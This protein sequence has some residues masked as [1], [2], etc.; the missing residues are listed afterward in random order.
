M[1]AGDRSYRGPARAICLVAAPPPYWER[2][3]MANV[4]SPFGLQD[5]VHQGGSQRT[6]ELATAWIAS[7]DPTPIFNGDIVTAIN[8]VSSTL[9]T[10]GVGAYITQASSQ[11]NPLVK[12]VF[13]GCEYFNLA[14]Q[15][16]FLSRWWPG[17]GIAGTSSQ[18][19]DVKAFFV[20]DVQQR[21]IAQ[22]SSLGLL[23][24]SNVGQFVSLTINGAAGNASSAV[25]NYATGQSGVQVGSSGTTAIT[26]T[27]VYGFPFRMVDLLSNT[28]AG[29]NP[30]QGFP[31]VGSSLGFVNGTDNTTVGQ[32]VVVEPVY[33]EGKAV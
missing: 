3:R 1:L 9:L 19:G 10:G 14:A 16:M 2:A 33:W 25:G 28:G 13:R 18:S 15:K 20:A 27:G 12:G 5:Y 24:S 7:S 30:L 26:S 8:P 32:V 21:F 4:L 17:S 22:A 11:V 29:G 23:G 31:G 6:E